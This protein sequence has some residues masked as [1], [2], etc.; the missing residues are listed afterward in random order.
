MPGLT[1]TFPLRDR[2]EFFYCWR[3]NNFRSSACTSRGTSTTKN[4]A[5]PRWTRFCPRTY[6]FWV[7]FHIW[8][9][10]LYFYCQILGFFLNFLEICFLFQ[11]WPELRTYFTPI[12]CATLERT[13]TRFPHMRLPSLTKYLLFLNL[14][15]FISVD[16]FEIPDHQ[17]DFGRNSIPSE[18]LPGHAQLLQLHF[19]NVSA[20]KYPKY[21]FP[22][23][24]WPTTARVDFKTMSYQFQRLKHMEI[25]LF[26]L[27][28]IRFQIVKNA[29]QYV[30]VLNEI[31]E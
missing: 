19:G 24:C 8:F 3:K 2:F 11:A 27:E 16:E 6:G 23:L 28:L 10:T 5:R 18:H 31:A 17:G 1:S 26:C 30:I 15:N 9:Q 13:A 20:S 22:I 4:S 14:L 7:N 25:Y 12:K 21:F 29:N